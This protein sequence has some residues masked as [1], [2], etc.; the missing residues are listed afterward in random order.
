MSKLVDS[1]ERFF[2]LLVIFLKIELKQ[3]NRTKMKKKME[4]KMS[5]NG[6][7]LWN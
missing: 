5:G 2:L 4:W 3:R 6:K 7:S 1:L